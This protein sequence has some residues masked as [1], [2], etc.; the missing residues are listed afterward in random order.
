LSDLNA[1]PTCPCGVVPVPEDVGLDGEP[2]PGGA[3]HAVLGVVAEARLKVAV[4]DGGVKG[5]LCERHGWSF[6]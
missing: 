1:T 3:P 4:G 2:L 5:G 6:S